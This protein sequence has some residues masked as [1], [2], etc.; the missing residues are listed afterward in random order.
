MNEQVVTTFDTGVVRTTDRVVLC[1][2]PSGDA[3]LDPLGAR[4]IDAGVAQPGP[5]GTGV[6]VDPVT[7]ALIDAAGVVDERILTIGPPRRGVL[8]ETTAMPEIRHQ[9]V[10]VAK[11]VLGIEPRSGS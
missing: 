1:T 4:I 5:F 7:G 11:R 10:D 9:A 2:G 3:H 6:L 8:W